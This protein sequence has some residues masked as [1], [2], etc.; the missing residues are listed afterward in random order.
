MVR[1]RRWDQAANQTLGLL[2][3]T[4]PGSGALFVYD[5]TASKLYH[6]ES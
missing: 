5:A 6:I 3:H 1:G 4:R 2:S